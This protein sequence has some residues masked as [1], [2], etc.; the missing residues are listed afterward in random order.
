MSQILFVFLAFSSDHLLSRGSRR[1]WELSGTSI[2]KQLIFL[3][4]VAD[5]IAD[6]PFPT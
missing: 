5:I 6:P 3:L 1:D 4:K 2:E